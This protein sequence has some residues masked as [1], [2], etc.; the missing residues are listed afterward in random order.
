M[1]EHQLCVLCI[2]VGVGVGMIVTFSLSALVTFAFG[3]NEISSKP[4]DS[5][6]SLD[7]GGME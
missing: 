7:L 6:I 1:N 3:L 5:E 2:A 4:S